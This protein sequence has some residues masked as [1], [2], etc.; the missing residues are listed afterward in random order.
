M[1]EES[2]VG[3]LERSSRFLKPVFADDTIYPALEVSELTPGRTTGVELA[4]RRVQSAPRTGAGRA[5][6]VSRPPP[7]L[8]SISPKIL[9]F[10]IFARAKGCR[11]EARGLPIEP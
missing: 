2:L 5:A 1:V 10:A 9:A 11:I 6:E 7:A 3:F 4:R 8:I